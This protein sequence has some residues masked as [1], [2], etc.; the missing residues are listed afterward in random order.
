M[1]ENTTLARPYARALFETA[2]EVRRRSE[3]ARKRDLGERL[4][5]A[6]R[7]GLPRHQHDCP[8]QPDAF[9]EF[10]Q[11]LANQRPKNSMKVE[12]RKTRRFRD[13]L[14]LQRLVEILQDEVDGPVNAFDVVG[15]IAARI[16]RIVSQDL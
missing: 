1:A 14:Q 6:R 2:R 10:I 5:L 12:R 15:R 7:P 16:F 4:P 13:N 11:G 3:A 9:H 8:F